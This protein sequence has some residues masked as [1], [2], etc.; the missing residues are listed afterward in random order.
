MPVNPKERTGL[1]GDF[2]FNRAMVRRRIVSLSLALMLVSSTLGLVAAAHLP[3]SYAAFP[4]EN[5]KI[6]FE[7]AR[8]GGVPNVG[9]IE[10]YS[11]NAD[12]TEQTRLTDDPSID[13]MAE[14]SPD[15]QKIVFA[16]NRVTAGGL[17]SIFV[18]NADGSDIVQLT[19]STHGGYNPTWSPDG[20]KIAFGGLGVLYVMD[21]DGSNLK[22][23]FSESASIGLPDWSPDGT[24][25]VFRSDMD[26]NGEI[27]SI[28]S[29]GSSE[30]VNLT[31]N[32]ADDSDPDWS[33]DGTKIAF[34][35]LRDPN[36]EIY[37]MNADGSDQVRISASSDT[38]LVEGIDADP[39]WSPD[40]THI[41]FV[42]YNEGS[43]DIYVMNA[44]GSGKTNVLNDTGAHDER[45]NWGVA[46]STVPEAH[47]FAV[48]SA[49]LAGNS[50]A[51]MWT[52]VRSLDGTLLKSG[53][54][55]LEFA[56][57]PGTEYRI[58]VA[59]Y[60]GRIFDHWQDDASTSKSR[61]IELTS[62]KEIVAIY[63]AG[64]SL[65]G[66]TSLTYA[67]TEGQPDLTVNATSLDGS[68]TLHMWTIIDPQSTDTSGTTYKL[69]A[70]NYKDRVFDHWEDGSTSMTRILT[71]EEGTSI[72][73]YYKTG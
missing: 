20:N 13:I 68:K 45:P 49:D 23:I 15:A 40:G 29:D 50:L 3:P 66:Y 54:T 69:Y 72:T 46:V 51:G 33:P 28:N 65:R 37:V 7:S 42:A 24:K 70:S 58:T 39:S 53:F 21:A 12:G 22:S 8:N 17:Y 43:A 56:G 26:G 6:V 9:N 71:I 5:G 60:D 27:Y 10:I 19:N 41:A 55:P 57:D 61:V 31:K 2:S 18:M 62:D 47:N 1:S 32:P 25:I 63:D 34:T 67:G 30:P 38:S 14:L 64:D 48:T 16:S 59:N 36:A 4:G 52:T 11:M 35:S 73:A 44:D